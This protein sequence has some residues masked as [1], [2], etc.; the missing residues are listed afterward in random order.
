MGVCQPLSGMS[1]TATIEA[2][3]TDRHPCLEGQRPSVFQPRGAEPWRVIP[4]VLAA[5]PGSKPSPPS[6]RRRVASSV[7]SAI[8][9]QAAGF[10]VQ[11]SGSLARCQALQQGLDLVADWVGARC[12]RSYCGVLC[13]QKL[14]ILA[15]LVVLDKAVTHNVIG[16]FN[17][18]VHHQEI[19]I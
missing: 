5:S 15:V 9:P 18:I 2:C 7:C 10:C 6:T 14:I 1:C 16:V 13:C 17:R 12:F 11:L 8:A 4:W 3:I 19:R